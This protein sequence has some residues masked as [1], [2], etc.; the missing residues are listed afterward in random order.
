MKTKSAHQEKGMQ[1][2]HSHGAHGHA[3]TAGHARHEPSPK[4]REPSGGVGRA[5]KGALAVLTL[6][7][8]CVWSV[9]LVRRC[10]APEQTDAEAGADSDEGS[11]AAARDLAGSRG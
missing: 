5:A 4:P 7:A 6:A 1:V 9:A 11:L 10:D 8:A 3:V 2:A